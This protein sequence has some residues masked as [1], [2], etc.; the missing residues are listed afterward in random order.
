MP[1]TWGKS[2]VRLLRSPCV[3]ATLFLAVVYP[4]LSPAQN[5]QVTVKN[6]EFGAYDNFSASPAEASGRVTVRCD[7]AR[8]VPITVFL[9]SGAHSSGFTPRRMRHGHREDHLGYLIFTDA[10]MTVIW[11]DGTRGSSP[12]VKTVGAG[13]TLELPVYGRIPPGQDVSVGRFADR[14]LVRVDW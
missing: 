4:S 2:P 3:A 10:S 11:G 14:V 7:G 9:D 5:C 13:E 6:L 1:T 12:V 8:A